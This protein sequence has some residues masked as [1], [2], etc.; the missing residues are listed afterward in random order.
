VYTGNAPRRP[1]NEIE[2]EVLRKPN[3]RKPQPNSKTQQAAQ[4]ALWLV[5]T[6]GK[7]ATQAS[8]QAALA[9]KVNP[10]NVRRYLRKLL[11]GPT[12]EIELKVPAMYSQLAPSGNEQLSRVQVSLVADLDEVNAAFDAAE[13]DTPPSN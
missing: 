8:L 1:R 9:F 11:K 10:D 2:Q 7:N 5:N 13:F 6:E 12:V 3:G 4:T